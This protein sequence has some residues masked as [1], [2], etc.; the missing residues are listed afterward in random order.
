MCNKCGTQNYFAHPCETPNWFC[1]E[2]GHR[3]YAGHSGGIICC[4]QCG[5]DRV[6]R[7]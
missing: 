5:D 3:F 2:C 4:P 1:S 6:N 7:L